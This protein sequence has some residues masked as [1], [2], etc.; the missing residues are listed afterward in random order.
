[1]HIIWTREALNRLTEI[2]EYI[3]KD[4]Q[5]RAINFV[6]YLIDQGETLKDHPKIGRVVPEVGN[7]NIR[8]I[9]AKKYRIIYRVTEERVEILT[10]FEG[11]RLLRLEELGA[12]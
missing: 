6:N 5:Q 9:I 7:E 4:S 10:V 12:N 2:E 8:E 1:M 3:A 11:H